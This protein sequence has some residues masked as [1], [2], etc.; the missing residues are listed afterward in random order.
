M[1][2][3]T[4]SISSFEGDY[5]IHVDITEM[6]TKGTLTQSSTPIIIHSSKKHELMGDLPLPA[7]INLISHI[8]SEEVKFV[9]L[10][11]QLLPRLQLVEHNHQQPAL[12]EV[13]LG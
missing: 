3:Q 6:S 12:T 1:K 2:L 10:I 4:G 7:K 11:T 5:Y 8:E 13:G 9:F